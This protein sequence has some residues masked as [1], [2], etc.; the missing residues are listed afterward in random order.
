MRKNICDGAMTALVT[1]F[2]KKGQ[3]S[4]QAVKEL[5]EFQIASGIAGIYV[6]GSTGEAMVLP[7]S[8]RM[9]MAELSVQYAAGRIPVIVHVGTP[10]TATAVAL[11]R[12]AQDIGA[13]GI[14]AVPPYYYKMTLDTVAKHYNT[15]ADAVDIPFLLYN[16]PNL[17]G[18]SLGADFI[19][20]MAEHPNIIGSKFSDMNLEDLRKIRA[21][22]NGKIKVFMGF[23][24]MLLS[25]LV[26]GAN[27]GIGTFYNVMPGP[28][29]TI[30][31]LFKAGQVEQAMAIQWEVCRYI[32]IMKKYI[33]IGL[34]S[35]M[36]VILRET[37]IDC[38]EVTPPL[39]SLNEQ[40]ATGLIKELREEGFFSFI[41][42]NGRKE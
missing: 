8:T 19:I 41:A 33:G 34:Q 42:N 5:V 14:S 22:D 26:M 40:A 9:R 13:D 17:T 2:D 28:L 16:I 29:S 37:G 3:V 24:A 11:A 32:T 7:E 25:A 35:G 1:P 39:F 6:S 20:K 12:H 36:K 10:D 18:I 30:F 27:G 4:Q 23:D 31:N 21:V 15:I 38:G